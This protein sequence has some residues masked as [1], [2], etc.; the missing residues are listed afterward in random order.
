MEN[1]SITLKLLT[2]RM[3]NHLI[4][5]SSTCPLK[6]LY[7][8]KFWLKIIQAGRVPVVWGPFKEDVTRLA[9]TTLILRLVLPLISCI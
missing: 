8:E 2:K 5:T 6:T 3:K 7:T 9:P 1:V 4:L